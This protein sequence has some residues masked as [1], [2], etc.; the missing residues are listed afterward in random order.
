ME[1]ITQIITS[2]RLNKEVLQKYDSILVMKN[3][4]LIESGN[5]NELIEN[6]GEFW[7]L[8]KTKN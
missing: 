3:G 5:F 8:Y 1:G 6:K 2:H 4:V 7:A